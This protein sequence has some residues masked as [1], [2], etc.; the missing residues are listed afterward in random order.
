[1]I[2]HLPGLRRQMMR[3]MSRALSE[4]QQ[5]LLNLGRR[6]SEGRIAALL[7][8]LSRRRELR[9]FRA[10]EVRLS[11]K[12]ADLANFLHM[13]VETVS[14]IL[15]KLQADEIIEVGRQDGA[16]VDATAL[17]AQAGRGAWAADR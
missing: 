15:H 10:C 11:M 3:L 8:S 1:M 14:R 16:L 2:D 6:D 4:D 17:Q 5:Q 13:R 7:L 9:G 12:R